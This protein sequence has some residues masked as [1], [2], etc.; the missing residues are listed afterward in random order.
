MQASLI[1]KKETNAWEDEQHMTIREMCKLPKGEFEVK[2]EGL[3]DH[4]KE[5]LA[6]WLEVYRKQHVGI[7]ERPLERRGGR[8]EEN[9]QLRKRGAGRIHIL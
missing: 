2:K 8:K 5:E 1:L 6:E 9:E 7:I 4:L 3:L